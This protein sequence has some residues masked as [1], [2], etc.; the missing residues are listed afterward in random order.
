MET[1]AQA[2]VPSVAELVRWNRLFFFSPANSVSLIPSSTPGRVAQSCARLEGSH[3]GQLL[4][5]E[6]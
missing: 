6:G 2:R 1:E 5:K 4:Q 3:E